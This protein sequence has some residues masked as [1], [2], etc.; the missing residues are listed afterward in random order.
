MKKAPFVFHLR[1]NLALAALAAM[2]V[3]KN[4]SD[5]DIDP[6]NRKHQGSPNK[7]APPRADHRISKKERKRREHIR[8]MN[9]NRKH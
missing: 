1:P 8:R 5:R 3:S 6:P 7:S 9:P 2:I 4:M